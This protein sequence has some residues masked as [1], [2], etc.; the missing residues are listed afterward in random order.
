DKLSEND[1]VFLIKE[2][3]NLNGEKRIQVV[4]TQGYI[5]GYIPKE[6]NVVLNNLINNGKYIYGS[7]KEITNNYEYIKIDLYLSYKDVMDEITST[8]SLLSR[9]KE[10][11]LQ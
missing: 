10:E 6:D 3:N 9:T 1:T 8:L 4:T 7:I 2:S 11:Y 5:I